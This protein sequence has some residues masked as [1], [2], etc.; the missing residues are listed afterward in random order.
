MNLILIVLI[1]K[2]SYPIYAETKTRIEGMQ[3]Q[4]IIKAKM[5]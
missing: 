3:Q 1:I 4:Y 2:V 5:T